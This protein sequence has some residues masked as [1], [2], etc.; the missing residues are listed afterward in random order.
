MVGDFLKDSFYYP[1]I[2]LK[3]K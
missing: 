1:L 2:N 3:K